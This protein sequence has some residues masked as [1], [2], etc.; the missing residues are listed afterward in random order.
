M[1]ADFSNQ[2]LSRLWVTFA[3]EENERVA[4]RPSARTILCVELGRGRR[5]EQ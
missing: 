5:I 3:C 2:Q 4:L 1:R